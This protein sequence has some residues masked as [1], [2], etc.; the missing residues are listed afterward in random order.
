[1]TLDQKGSAEFDWAS[2]RRVHRAW[3]IWGAIAIL[4]PLAALVMMILKVPQ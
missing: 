4:T 2:F 1:M 3:D